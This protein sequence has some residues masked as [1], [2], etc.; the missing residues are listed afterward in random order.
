V[1]A[2]ARFS[3]TLYDIAQVFESAE[4]S[5]ERVLHVLELVGHVVPEFVLR[6]AI[7]F[8]FLD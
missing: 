2:R 3:R 1:T 7:P 6:R 8:L 5:E 4:G